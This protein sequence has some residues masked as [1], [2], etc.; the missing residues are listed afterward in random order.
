MLLSI[1]KAIVVFISCVFLPLM[2]CVAQTDSASNTI[3][4]YNPKRLAFVTSA[5]VVAFTGTMIGLNQLWFVDYPHT[6]FHFFNDGADW[7]QMDKVG[8]SY[9]SYTVGKIGIDALK[10]S[11]VERKKAI[12]FGGALGW[13]FLSAVELFDAFS[14]GWGFSVSDIGANTLGAGMLISQELL[15]KEQ[16]VAFKYSFQQSMYAQ[17]RPE[18][19]GSSIYEN[20]LKDYN[21]QT[22]WLSVNIASFLKKETQFPKWL[23]VALGYGADGMISGNANT[24]V[25]D[26]YGNTLYFER[27]RQAY[28]SLDL[29]LTRVPVKHKFLRI[30][31]NTL[32]CIKFPFPAIEFSKHGTK[33]NAIGF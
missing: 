5:E 6:A 4:A 17:Y 20:V 9:T 2:V 33:I 13:T 21:G 19:L 15:W 18:L 8:H 24:S 23:N 12:W 27:Y 26:I 3:T 22:Y 31:F 10:W 1:R 28:L 16:R 11:G 25:V 7:M 29:D 30:I 14:Q 32:N